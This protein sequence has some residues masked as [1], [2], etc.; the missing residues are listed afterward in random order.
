M[1]RGARVGCGRAGASPRSPACGRAAGRRL[2]RA[3]SAAGAGHVQPRTSRRSCFEQLRALPSAGRGRARSA[4][5]PTPTSAGARSRSRASPPVGTCR[6]GRRSRA[7]A[8][9][10]GERRLTD[11]QIALIQRWVR[12]GTPEGDRR[13][14]SAAA[15]ASPRAGSSARRTWCWRR[16]SPTRSPPKARTCSATS[17]CPCRC[18][19]RATSARSSCGRATRRVVHHANVL[20]DR[21]RLRAAARRARSRARASAGMDVELESDSFEPDSHFLF[22]K[23]GTAAVSEPEDMAWRVDGDTDLVLNLHLQPSGKPEVI[24]PVVGLYFTDTPPT[25][26]S[27]CCSSSSTTAPSTSR[28]ARRTSR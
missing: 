2:R 16:R 12:E 3:A 7:T 14:P 1:T 19:G 4:C 27:R 25:P 9:S 8:S 6:P 10:P 22:W 20:L 23:P 21:T 18:P 13:R 15:R 26:P 28:P 24:R 11:E 5:S 17:S